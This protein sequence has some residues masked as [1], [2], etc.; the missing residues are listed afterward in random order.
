MKLINK[1]QVVLILS[2]PHLAVAF[3]GFFYLV[4]FYKSSQH[5]DEI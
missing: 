4:V 1:G 2:S 5:V 3:S